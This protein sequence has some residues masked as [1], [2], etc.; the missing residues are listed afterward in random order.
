[1]MGSPMRRLPLALLIPLLA[2]TIAPAPVPGQPAA[3]NR[4]AEFVHF[5]MQEIDR[6]LKVGYAVLVVDVNGDGKPDIV[7][8]DVD[9]V[10]WYENPSW[11][12]R[13]IIQG[14][15]K[16]DNVCIAAADIDGDGQLD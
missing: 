11:Q 13:T 5:R 9:R 4:S 14:Q 6:T 3:P 12:R 15:T 7:V 2:L 10:V 16:P 1:M 8:V